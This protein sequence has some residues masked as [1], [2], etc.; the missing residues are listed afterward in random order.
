MTIIPTT[1]LN[2]NMGTHVN[3]MTLAAHNLLP[4]KPI[5]QQSNMPPRLPG[6]VSGKIKL[7]SSEQTQKSLE[8]QSDIVFLRTFHLQ[9]TFFLIFKIVFQFQW[10]VQEA[11]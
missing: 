10:L 8:S 7:D 5:F 4:A 3:P 1:A 9:N 2:M 6:N 11:E